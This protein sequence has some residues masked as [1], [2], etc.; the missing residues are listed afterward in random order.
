LSDEG[1]CLVRKVMNDSQSGQGCESFIDKDFK[2]EFSDCCGIYNMPH[3][4]T[5][6]NNTT[7]DE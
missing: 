2:P 1:K 6:K 5:V 4:V 7:D 3:Q